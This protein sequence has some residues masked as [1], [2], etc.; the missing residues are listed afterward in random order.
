MPQTSSGLP[1]SSPG[2]RTAARRSLVWSVSGANGTPTAAATSATC[3]RSNPESCTVA[4]P[5]FRPRA[6]RAAGAE[7]LERV[8]QLGQVADAVHAVRG[9]Q[10]LPGAVA[11]RQRTRVGGDQRPAGGR[12][13][14]REQH[15]RDVAV[16]R[17]GEH[18]AQQRPVPDR[19]DDKREHLGLGEGERVPGVGGGGGDKLLAGRDRDREAERPPG[20]QQGREDRPGVRDQRHRSGRERVGLEVADR[21]Q[22]AGH[23]HEPHAPGPAH[24][25]PRVP[26]QRGDPVAEG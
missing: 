21:A 1:G 7:Q 2:S 11:R 3:A 10:R 14:G 13:A 26:G 23:V 6:V 25:H 19:L 17:V 15:D 8:R 22:P 18:A 12:G 16:G 9:R 5:A 24:R 4:S 20:S